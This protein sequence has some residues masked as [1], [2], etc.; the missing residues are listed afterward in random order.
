[1]SNTINSFGGFGAESSS[2]PVTV[3]SKDHLVPINQRMY[4]TGSIGKGPTLLEYMSRPV[5]VKSGILA[6]TDGPTTFTHFELIH[7]IIGKNVPSAHFKG[8]YMV[9]ADVRLRLQ[10]NANKFQ[11]GRY[12]LAHIP[13]GGGDLADPTVLPFIKMHRA[14]IVHVTQLHHVEIDLNT[15]SEVELLIPYHGVLQGYIYNPAGATRVH[16]DIGIAF[17]YPYSPL[18]AA[19][20]VL[21]ASYTIYANLEN[22]VLSGLA[23][24]QMAG[25][26]IRTEQKKAKIGAIESTLKLASKSANI[27]AE[28]PVLTSV[29]APAGWVTDVLARAAHVWGWSR[30]TN[31]APTKRVTVG[32]LSYQATSDAADT[33]QPLSLISQNAVTLASGMART[34]Q[35]EM[36]FAYLTGIYS[37]ISS[38]QF[39]TSDVAGA[40]L[41]TITCATPSLTR[42]FTEGLINYYS[43]PPIT[44]LARKFRYLRGGL[45]FRFK[46]V[47]TELHSGRLMIVF[48]PTSKY[49]QF[50]L[51]STLDETNWVQRQIVDIKGIT[52]FEFSVPF[53]YPKPWMRVSDTVGFGKVGVYV[54]NPLIAPATV[55]NYI[56]LKI[57]VC[58]ADDF[59]YAVPLHN[60]SQAFNVPVTPYT[61]QMDSDMGALSGKLNLG[62]I[63]GSSDVS[64]PTADA[65]FCIGEKVLSIRS[66]LKRYTM[67]YTVAN[68]ALKLNKLHPCCTEVAANVN[69][70]TFQVLDKADAFDFFC[71]LFVY[72]RGAVRVRAIETAGAALS[73][74]VAL[75]DENGNVNGKGYQSTGSVANMYEYPALQTFQ[76]MYG[77]EVQVP[78]YQGQPARL[79]AHEL[80]NLAAGYQSTT[81]DFRSSLMVIFGN[82][83]AATTF[84]AWRAAGDDYQLA[85][86]ISTVPLY[87][88]AFS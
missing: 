71:P 1:M 27:L 24:P 8:S 56:E 4:T 72:S 39:Q 13:L 79:Q 40:L 73:M 32:N 47:K 35:D 69:G 50:A 22:I 33:A 6:P 86:F 17:L 85:G 25:D 44:Y 68:V 57:E 55:L 48:Q 12:I 2:E 67:M 58:G 83:V 81:T 62:C 64:D 60:A 43:D 30:P 34:D 46:L 18:A 10:V 51:P 7:Q 78:Q 23:V 59:E 74:F 54:L 45:K 84:T 77:T 87:N 14:N 16:G 36:S 38:I 70:T 88:A 19:S 52:E 11:A 29:A 15:Q 20:G 75:S 42:G 31:L 5:V 53:I 66:I 37:N 41:T 82:T 76:N 26:P 28:I 9:R 49:A 65:E 63:A 21:D 61:Y 3:V 80:F